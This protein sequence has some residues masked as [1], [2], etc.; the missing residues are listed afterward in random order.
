MTN[1]DPQQLLRQVQRLQHENAQLR[2]QASSESHS[3]LMAEEELGKTEDHLQLALDAAGLAMWQWDLDSATVFTSAHFS[4]LILETSPGQTQGRTWLADEILDRIPADDR[5]RLHLAIVQVLKQADHR[6]DIEFKIQTASAL[7][8]MECTGEVTRRDMLGRAS[9]VVGIVR[10]VTRR[11]D[12][13]QEIMAAREQAEA[14]HAQA[15]SANA[16]KDDFL[17]HISHEIRTPLN[18]VIGMNNLLAQTSL[19]PEQRQYVELV[20]SSGRALL[21]LVNDV[22]DYSRLEAHKLILE[23]VRFP[24]RRWLWEVVAPQRVAAQAKGLELL[25]QAG[26]SL[27]AE[28][29]GDPGRLRQIVTN[30]VSN[31]IKFTSQGRVD[32]AMWASGVQ[33]H[34]FELH[35]RVSDTGI[36][37]AQDKQAFIFGAF[38]QADSSTSRLYGGSGLGL[39]ICNKLAQLMG[40]QIELDSAPGEGSRFSVHV[41]LSLADD[42]MPS[43]QFGD[44]ALVDSEF[45]AGA[46]NP[47]NSHPASLNAILQFSGKRALVVDDHAVNQLLARKLL[48][49][50]GFQVEV[51]SDGEFALQAI[52]GGSFDVVL[53]D[54]QMPRMN[55]WQATHHIRQFEKARKKIRVP[56]I[57]LSAHASAA[58]REQ[59]LAGGMDGYLSKPLTPEALQAAL[60]ATGLA[61]QPGASDALA[62]DAGMISVLPDEA[63][64]PRLAKRPARRAAGSPH[65]HDRSRLLAR[66][67]GDEAALKAM[68][69]AFREDLRNTMAAAFDALKKKDWATTR[70]QAHALKGLLASMTADAAAQEAK[71][72]EAAAHDKD[73]TQARA[74]FQRLSEAAKHVFHSVNSW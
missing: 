67:G 27:P 11:R 1:L 19:S 4:Q 34:E 21:A 46:A 7:I 73:I 51:A 57:A 69:Q 63:S 8:W 28:A 59:A 30:L 43:T 32:V 60:R 44:D 42:D 47:A 40:G 16:A 37:I 20:S 58:D 62:P 56:I 10:D 55:G 72:L 50:R 74:A 52:H 68:V 39:S 22:L 9:R 24:L 65:P 26:E 64:P 49:Q 17:A 33:E 6:L 2:E 38:V 18:G 23:Q 71:A 15:I 45:P 29:V 5:R 35:L 53:M 31:A 3:R 48:E 61:M 13:Q 66:L 70:Q 36:G 54:I 25:L 12:I 41:P 14:A